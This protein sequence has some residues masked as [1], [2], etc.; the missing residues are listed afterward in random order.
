MNQDGT[1]E[2]E[3]DIFDQPSLHEEVYKKNKNPN[4]L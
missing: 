3:K 2:Q 1:K 4:N